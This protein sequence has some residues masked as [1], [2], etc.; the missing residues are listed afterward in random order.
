MSDIQPLPAIRY[1]TR[2]VSTKLAPPYDVLSDA[3]KQA[4]LQADPHNFVRIDLPHTPPKAAGPAKLYADARADLEQWLA[5]GVLTRDTAPAIYVYHQH[6]RSA[7]QDYVRKMFFARLRLER[8]GEGSVFPHEQTFGGPKE[9]RLA[10][11]KAT[12]TNLSPIFALYPDRGNEVAALLDGAL[13]G[14]SLLSGVLDNV[15]SDVWAVRDSAVVESVQAL[16]R[17][18]PVFIADGHHRYGTGLLYREWLDQERGGLDPDHP[19][20]F[21]LCVLCAMEDDGLQILPTHRVL[22]KQRVDPEVLEKDPAI[23]MTPAAATTPDE[24]VQELAEHGPQAM[25]L[26]D[27]SREAYYVLK[28]QD[29]NLLAPLAQEHSVAWRKLGLAFLH[30]YVLDQVVA[31][32][33]GAEPE[34]QYVKATKAA[35]DIAVSG[36]GSAFLMQATTMDELRAVCQAG[37]LMPQK[38]T[39]FYPKLASGLIINP[40]A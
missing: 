17:D 3:D 12:E 32:S 9:D 5:D 25:S 13:S 4:L 33:I 38:S 6:Y 1:A 31:R 26:F 28:P 37:D 21:V 20:Q 16:M 19:A 30:A 27:G 24:V 22:G 39:Y 23:V 2:D 7:G 11:T 35:V 36:G 29:P 15:K 10:L 40:L 34:I 8:F 14:E 18:K